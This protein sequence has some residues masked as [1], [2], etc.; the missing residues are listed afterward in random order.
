MKNIRRNILKW[1]G[2]SAFSF[3]T[4]L[5]FLYITFPREAILHRLKAEVTKASNG[6]VTLNTQKL[7]LAGIS[8]ISLKEINIFIA[9]DD[10]AT[11]TRLTIDSLEVKIH[12]FKTIKR[13]ITKNKGGLLGPIGGLD[14]TIIQGKGSLFATISEEEK[15]TDL[16]VNFEEL[17]LE[18]LLPAFVSI[19]LPVRAITSG[20]LKAKL[21]NQWY[22]NGEGSLEL[23]LKNC[24]LGAGTVNTPLGPFE[25]PLIDFG[26]I[27]T[28]MLLERGALKIDKWQQSGRDLVESSINGKIT[29]QKR[30]ESSA[31]DLGISLKPGSEFLEKNSKFGAMIAMAGLKKDE[32]DNYS[33]IISGRFSDPSAKS[34]KRRPTPPRNEAAKGRGK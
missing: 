3:F 29:L 19:P 17:R 9:G 21:K 25:L 7:A 31:L 6:K 8:G 15:A 16:M 33:F 2:Y 12:L 26:T 18:R 34:G 13:L 27:S 24:S 23:R 20:T 5:L 1:L 10:N 22:T 14:A 11:P 32:D 30:L 28:T 4:F